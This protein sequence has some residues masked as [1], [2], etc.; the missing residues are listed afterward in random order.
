MTV[1]VT[2]FSESEELRKEN[3]L[4]TVVIREKYK[5]RCLSFLTIGHNNGVYLKNYTGKCQ[6]FQLILITE[7]PV[8][9][10]MRKKIEDQNSIIKKQENRIRKLEEIIGCQDD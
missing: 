2:A 9:Y 5:D 1:W 10:E 4:G 6:Q 3:T 7:G 8:I